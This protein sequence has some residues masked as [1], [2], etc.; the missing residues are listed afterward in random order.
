MKT[1]GMLTRISV[2]PGARAE[3]AIAAFLCRLLTCA[4]LLV[5]PLQAIV[6]PDIWSFP[7]MLFAFLVGLAVIGSF[8]VALLMYLKLI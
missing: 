6:M 7:R 8:V 1:N 2:S 4:T 5:W 3:A